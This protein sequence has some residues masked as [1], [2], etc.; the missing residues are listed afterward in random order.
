V[1]TQCKHCP[2]PTG[3]SRSTLLYGIGNSGETHVR[4]CRCGDHG[5]E[6]WHEEARQL[7]GHGPHFTETVQVSDGYSWVE[8]TVTSTHP[9][10]EFMYVRSL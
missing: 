8:L 2:H 10:G 7:K 5:V 4:C 9:D 1:K 3:T 6:N